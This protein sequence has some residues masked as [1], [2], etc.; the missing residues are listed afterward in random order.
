M[1]GAL[2]WHGHQWTTVMPSCLPWLEAPS[3]QGW[4]LD[5]I[6]S[7]TF[8]K[9]LSLNHRHCSAITWALLPT[10]RSRDACRRRASMLVTYIILYRKFQSSK[11]SKMQLPY[12][13][14][15]TAL[16]TYVLRVNENH[17]WECPVIK[18]GMCTICVNAIIKL[19][20][21][22]P[23]YA[24]ALV[25]GNIL[26]D[27]CASS[28]GV[29]S[30][31]WKRL[32]YEKPHIVCSTEVIHSVILAYSLLYGK[33]QSRHANAYYCNSAAHAHRD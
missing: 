10:R 1:L 18:I 9:A 3:L 33:K 22:T 11:Q 8:A 16:K 24:Y 20:T 31:A 13:D 19:A 17:V 21:E 27:I 12:T 30:V 2:T 7:L 15:S 29:N 4:P 23:K 5:Q 26:V 14:Y 28:F 32:M 6:N 25:R